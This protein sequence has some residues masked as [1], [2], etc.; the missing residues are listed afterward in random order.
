MAFT[1]QQYDTLTAAIAEG[2]EEVWYGDKKVKYKSLDQMLKVLRLMENDLGIT[3]PMNR[4]VRSTFKKG[5][6]PGPTYPDNSSEW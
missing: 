3:D 1:Q 2:T 4:V 5:L 6:Y